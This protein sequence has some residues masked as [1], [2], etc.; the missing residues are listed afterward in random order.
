MDYLNDKRC[1]KDKG[2]WKMQ[3]RIPIT[4]TFTQRSK[5]LEIIDRFSVRDK[6]CF[7]SN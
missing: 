4:K 6:V 2:E 7:S 1:V 5:E 3:L